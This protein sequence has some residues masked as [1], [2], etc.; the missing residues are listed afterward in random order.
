[1]ASETEWSQ[2]KKLIDFSSRPGGFRRSLVPNIPYF[3]VQWDYKGEKG[4]GHVIEGIEDA[5][6]RGEG[7]E[8][9]GGPIDEG[10]RG[11]G[12]FP[13][14]VILFHFHIS[15][16]LDQQHQ[17]GS[18]LMARYF[19]AEIIGNLLDLE[20]IKWRKPKKLDYGLNQQRAAKLGQWFQPYN[21][22]TQLQSS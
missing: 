15:F 12:Q 13:P 7:E 2:H 19:A 3:M 5:A 9:M 11:G 22:T 18:E 1:M 14:Y 20:P 10:D 4:Y 16:S 21:W 17:W 8:G 6:G